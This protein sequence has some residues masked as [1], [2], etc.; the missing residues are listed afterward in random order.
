M[1]LLLQT[2][3]DKLEHTVDFSAPD[4]SQTDRANR[5]PITGRH[6][7]PS[8]SPDS[9]PGQMTAERH[10]HARRRDGERGAERDDG[11]SGPGGLYLELESSS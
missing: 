5:S 2:S 11:G 4:I 6:H 1:N 10:R 7:A 8:T 9:V 3:T